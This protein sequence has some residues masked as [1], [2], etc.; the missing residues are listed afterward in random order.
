MS[1]ALKIVVQRRWRRIRQRDRR[2]ARR[3]NITRAR[4]K[5][6]F[7]EKRV[8]SSLEENRARKTESTILH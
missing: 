7:K 8:A 3:V 1:I 2:R 4:E 6:C 5:E